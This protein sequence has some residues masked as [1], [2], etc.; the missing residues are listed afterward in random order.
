[1]IRSSV[2]IKKNYNHISMHMFVKH[3]NNV[4]S[5][6]FSPLPSISGT[7]LINPQLACTFAGNTAFTRGLL[8]ARKCEKSP[9]GRVTS[10]PVESAELLENYRTNRAD[11][12]GEEKTCPRQQQVV[13]MSLRD[14]VST[15]LPQP[16]SPHG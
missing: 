5:H 12:A 11:F 3:D 16:V 1:M 2:N 4:T 9:G 13:Q 8:Q 14:I 10:L 7:F 6:A 15:Q